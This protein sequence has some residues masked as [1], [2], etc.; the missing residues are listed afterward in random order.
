MNPGEIS[1]LNFLNLQYWYCLI[2]S[3]FGGRCAPVKPLSVD[4]DATISTSPGTLATGANAQGTVG[5]W[6]W[7]FGG[8]HSSS[9]LASLVPHGGFFG[10]FLD[11]VV[12]VAGFIGTLILFLW[13]LFSALSYAVS[14][15]LVLLIIF[16]IVGLLW[17]RMEESGTYGTLP[18]RETVFRPL[19]ERW[20][21][22]LDGAMS[23][24][25]KR[26]R[27]GIL[28]ADGMLGELLGKLSYTGA[29]T[30]ERLRLVPEN[31]FV[32]L[33]LAWE[34]HRIRNLTVTQTSNFILTQRE[35]FRALKLYEQVFEEFDFI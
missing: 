35:A 25:P 17:L 11:A 15:F 27:E 33:P 21:T 5:F 26:W 29:T 19:Q 4:V 20:H 7:L 32:T 1:N 22:L 14:G 9:S 8:S 10:P 18:P 30:N 31:A 6:D 24:D 34:A 28:E 13:S 2:Y 23:N 3:L 12:V 16:S